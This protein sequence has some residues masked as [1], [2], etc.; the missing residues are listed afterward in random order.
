M[1]LHTIRH[2]LGQPL[3]HRVI[4]KLRQ[5][6][7]STSPFGLKLSLLGALLTFGCAQPAETKKPIVSDDDQP[8]VAASWKP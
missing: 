6:S 2:A 8:F 5:R 4:A 7:S 1:S 3:K